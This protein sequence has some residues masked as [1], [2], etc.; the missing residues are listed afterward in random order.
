MPTVRPSTFTR[1]YACYIGDGALYS[2]EA[3]DGEND[4]PEGAGYWYSLRSQEVSCPGCHGGDEPPGDGA[5][6]S[7]DGS[8][9]DPHG[10]PEDTGPNGE[11]LPCFDCDG[12]G[13]VKRTCATCDGS[14]MSEGEPFTVEQI[15]LPSA[16]D[17][18]AVLEAADRGD[19]YD[20]AGAL[21][22]ALKARGVKAVTVLEWEPE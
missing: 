3:H 6:E 20:N 9:N 14:G 1:L 8:G 21:A 13:T 22:E 11:P 19:M 10:E 4:A 16:D 5:C 18:S 12:K 2:L 7:C 15:D 17:V